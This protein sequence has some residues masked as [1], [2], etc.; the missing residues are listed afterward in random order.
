MPFCSWSSCF[1]NLE[2]EENKVNL[3]S[4]V[5]H[6]LSTGQAMMNFEGLHDLFIILKVKH[7]LK[8]RWS[9]FVGWDIAKSM[10]GLLWESIQNVIVAADFLSISV[11]EVTTID[12]A[13]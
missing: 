5:Y 11:Y 1:Q 3:V 8:K 9:D 13:S 4:F 2:R 7:I 12:N 6:L 10:N